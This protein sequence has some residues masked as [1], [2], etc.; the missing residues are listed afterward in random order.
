MD[1]KNKTIEDLKA[2]LEEEIN[3]K[4]NEVLI[5]AEYKMVIKK[6][7]MQIE[8]LNKIN[9]RLYTQVADLRVR[10]DIASFKQ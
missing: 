9:E 10:I 8:L 6:L 4:K 7:E 3:V 5:N 2:R 1:I